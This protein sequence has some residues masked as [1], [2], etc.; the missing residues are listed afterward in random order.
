MSWKVV[1]LTKLRDGRLHLYRQ[2]NCRFWICRF[3]AD[4]KY[5]VKST[6]ELSYSPAKSFAEDWYD[7]LRFR[8]KEYGEPI[9]DK[10]FSDVGRE[11]ILYQEGLV[12]RKDRTPEQASNYENKINGVLKYFDDTPISQLTR[13]KVDEYKTF[14]LTTPTKGKLISLNTVK[15]DFVAL[16]QVLKFATLQ[17]YIDRLPEFP[18]NKIV[19]NPRPWFDP[20]EWKQLL[21]ASR[22]RI[23]RARG[24]RQLWER[25]QLHDMML[26]MVHTGIRVQEC[27]NLRYGDCVVGKKKNKKGSMLKLELRGKTGIR[28]VIGTS[29]AVWVY[30]RLLVRNKHD[31]DDLLFPQHHRDGLNALLK[32]TGLKS[33]RFGNIR[34][35]KS[36]RSTYIMFRLLAKVP[37]KDIATNC[38]NSS[39]VIDKYYAKYLTVDMIAESLSDLPE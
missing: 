11:F 20:V 31:K 33:D 22:E 17:N 38:G 8:K 16:R 10:K 27:L 13:K 28:K 30:E 1:E 25:E 19:S 21:N 18:K 36:F 6:G 23:K 5:K 34:N 14:R 26:M 7:R 37:I 9:H 35:A 32:E 12:A 3:Y 24:T 39:D 15:H 4:G 2:D 29:G